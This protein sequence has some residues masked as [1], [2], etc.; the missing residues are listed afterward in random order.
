IASILFFLFLLCGRLRRSFRLSLFLLV[1]AFLVLRVFLVFWLW[2]QQVGNK[3]RA[4]FRHL[5]VFHAIYSA[6]V[7][8]CD[9]DDAHCVLGHVLRFLFLLLGASG[10]ALSGQDLKNNKARIGGEVRARRLRRSGILRKRIHLR[11][12][13]RQRASR[14]TP[15]LAGLEISNYN[16][17]VAI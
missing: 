9:V 8:A 17:S 7:A 13:S 3:A 16:F 14:S 6:Q 5:K 15:L 12:S 11:Y 4:L 2:L 10:L 1:V